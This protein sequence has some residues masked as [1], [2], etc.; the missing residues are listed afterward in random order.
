LAIL[1]D[2]KIPECESNKARLSKPSAKSQA[3]TSIKN[4]YDNGSSF[5]L[6]TFERGGVRSYAAAN[7]KAAA[8]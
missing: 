5:R 8:R 3:L 2:P 1:F 4:H 7:W 6:Q